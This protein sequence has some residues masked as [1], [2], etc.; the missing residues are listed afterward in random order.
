MRISLK[1]NDS[2]TSALFTMKAWRLRAIFSILGTSS[3]LCRDPRLALLLSTLDTVARFVIMAFLHCA[4][5]AIISPSR[6]C[7]ESTLGTRFR[8]SKPKQRPNTLLYL[9]LLGFKCRIFHLDAKTPGCSR[10]HSPVHAT[11]MKKNWMDHKNEE[12]QS[13]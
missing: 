8:I 1:R 11:R 3:V 10:S 6:Y 13:H 7:I 5:H 2:F 9:L 4:R 12:Y